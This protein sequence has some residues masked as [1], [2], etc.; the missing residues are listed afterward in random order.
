MTFDQDIWFGIVHV[1]W[2]CLGDLL[3][4]NIIRKSSKLGN[5]HNEEIV[6]AMHMYITRQEIGTHTRKLKFKLLISKK[7]SLQC[8]MCA[9]LVAAVFDVCHW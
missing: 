4:F 7:W 9:F 5:L 8:Q 1:C 6:S 3:S 2:S